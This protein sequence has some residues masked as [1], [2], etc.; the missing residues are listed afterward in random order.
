MPTPLSRYEEANAVAALPEAT[1]I[2]ADTN[3][4]LLEP[5]PTAQQA[6]AQ[7]GEQNASLA[8]NFLENVYKPCRANML[9]KGQNALNENRAKLQEMKEFT[10]LLNRLTDK[11][12]EVDKKESSIDLR[13]DSDIL[14]I[15][16]KAADMGLA[17]KDKTVLTR[18]EI[19]G[20]TRRL[21]TKC[22]QLQ[23]EATMA[24]GELQSLKTDLLEITKIAMKI[25]DRIDQLIKNI[26]QRSGK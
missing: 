15:L 12:E 26:I 24:M 11:L 19:N 21:Q 2:P 14:D 8:Y 6:I 20:I 16:K 5:I 13:N 23:Q 18:E 22:S 9:E 7:V 17:P 10:T 3:P 1:N 4:K 25:L